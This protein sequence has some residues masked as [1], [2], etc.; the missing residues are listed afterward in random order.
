MT[1]KKYFNIDAALKETE[2]VKEMDLPGLGI[3]KYKILTWADLHTL[4]EN[5]SPSDS[6]EDQVARILW[7][8]LN[9][10][11]PSVTF[12]MVKNLPARTLPAFTLL[13]EKTELIP[14]GKT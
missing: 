5:A 13:L 3:I 6:A 14:K 4:R 9:K 10:A 11:D 12:E 1:D 7:L 2:E 8:M